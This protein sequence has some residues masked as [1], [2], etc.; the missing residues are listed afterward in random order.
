MRSLSRR[1]PSSTT[2]S[3][4][5]RPHAAAPSSPTPLPQI[6]RS[7]YWGPVSS[8]SCRAASQRRAGTCTRLTQKSWTRDSRRMYVGDGCTV[9]A[10]DF[11]RWLIIGGL[12][13]AGV[14]FFFCVL[15][16]PYILHSRE[17]QDNKL[18][19]CGSSTIGCGIAFL[20]C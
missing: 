5:K 3:A 14:V 6:S 4:W 1:P 15:L 2:V 13:F 11:T 12:V 9:P 19:Y 16:S 7:P 17:H 18:W 8:P 20:L 10:V